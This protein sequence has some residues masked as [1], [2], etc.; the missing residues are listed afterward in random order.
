MQQTEV[1]C[2][3][4][5]NAHRA[6]CAITSVVPVK[7]SASAAGLTNGTSA[8]QAV[9]TPATSA[10]SVDTTIRSNNPEVLA[11]SIDQAIIGL[12]QKSRIFF[13]GMR[14]LPPR[15]GMTAM[16]LFDD[17]RFMRGAFSIPSGLRCCTDH[18]VPVIRYKTGLR[19]HGA[20]TTGEPGKAE[21]DYIHGLALDTSLMPNS[22]ER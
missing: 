14:L 22:I 13:R 15:A 17:G 3:R 18:F 6:A 11:A 10:S 16:A 7:S 12:P 9:A 2:Q 1:T 21:R 5:S 19:P 8:P 20:D 4:C